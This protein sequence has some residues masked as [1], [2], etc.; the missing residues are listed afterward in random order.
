MTDD[1]HVSLSISSPALS[2]VLLMSPCPSP[3]PLSVQYFSCL[4]VHLLARSQSSTSHVSLSIS[5]PALSPVLLMSPCP[6]PRP[7]SVQYFSCLPV[8]L[9][10]RSQS[11]TSHVSLSI[12]SPALSPVLLM[13]PCPSPRPLS[14]QYFS[15]LPFHLLAR[16]QSSTSHVSLSI[17]SPALSPVLLMS[18]C[19]SPRPLS[20][21]LM[22]RWQ[23]SY[24]LFSAVLA[25]FSLLYP[26]STHSS[27]CIPRLSSS[28]ARTISRFFGMC[29]TL[30]VPR[31]C[32]FL[33]ISFCVTPRIHRSTL[34]SFTSR[35]STVAPSPRSPHAHPP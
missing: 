19:P 16:S 20:V 5:S 21:L 9:L 30:V 28:H 6:S 1:V 27:V 23:P 7:L 29:T 2:P 14:V 15:C 34:T 31:M 22:S 8:H 10:A 12:S 35:A 32:S 11:S 3:R 24:H 18:P 13:S 17:S 25:S 33:I 26:S 4:P